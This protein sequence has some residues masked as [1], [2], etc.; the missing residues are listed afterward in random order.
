MDET[1]VDAITVGGR[2]AQRQ[3]VGRGAAR[4]PRSVPRAPGL[5]DRPALRGPGPAARAARGAGVDDAAER[6]SPRDSS[7]STARRAS[8]RGRADAGDLRPAPGVR[9]ADLAGELGR[10]T[11]VF[12]R[13]VRKLKELGLTE[14]LEVGYRLSPRGRAFMD[15]RAERTAR[16]RLPVI[17]KRAWTRLG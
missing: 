11:L 5:P 2:A 15:T 3:R 4:V 13:D 9:A 12:K 17:R 1:A 6:G 16:R 14:S 8:A 7:A 10:E